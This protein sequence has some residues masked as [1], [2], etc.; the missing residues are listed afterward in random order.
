MAQQSQQNVSPWLDGVR[1]VEVLPIIEADAP[2][3]RVEAGPGTGKTFGLTRLVARLVSPDGEALD[4]TRVLVAA[5]NRVIAKD[6]TDAIGSELER[7]GVET[8]PVVS[9]IHSF[10]VQALGSDDTRLLMPHEELSMLYDVATRHPEVAEP[11]TGITE[12]QR[13]FV[14]HEAGLENHPALWQAVQEWLNDHG[15]KLVGELPKELLSRIRG[16]DLQELL[17]DYVIVDEFQDLTATEQELVSKLVA[18][19]GKLMALGDSNQSIYAFRGNHPDGL[20]NLGELTGTTPELID[21][22]GCQRCPPEIVEIAN[23]LVALSGRQ[24]KPASTEPA[25]LHLLHWDSPAAEF[26][27]LAAAIAENV[28]AHPDDQHLVMVTRRAIAFELKNRLAE[29]NSD[30][31]LRLTFEESLIERWAVREAFLFFCLLTRPDPGTWRAW[32]SYS[33]DSE[34]PNAPK[35]NSDAYLK[36][37]DRCNDRAI[38]AE[39]VLALAGEAENAPRGSGGKMIWQRAA[40]FVQISESRDWA[41]MTPSQLVT[42]LFEPDS[43]FTDGGDADSLER[44]FEL[45]RG[46][47]TEII[48]DLEKQGLT[49]N[50]VLDRAAGELRLMI[51]TREPVDVEASSNLH[52]TTLW[53]AKGLTADHVYV[54]G[55]CEEA[56]PGV[57]RSGSPFTHAAFI[58]ECRRLFYVSVT[59]T[60]KTLVLSQWKRIQRSTALRLGLAAGDGGGN[61]NLTTSQFLGE[62]IELLPESE[63]G[64]SWGGC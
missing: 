21:M 33:V 45:I 56:L 26:D 29:I 63:S 59:R 16:G 13:A 18:P 41:S 51:A 55:L 48:Q 31:R 61:I 53:G 50:Q 43:L 27:G 15:C 54:L 39:D 5:F 6:L 37:K 3:S 44:D 32:F 4:P 25:N 38:R 42:E 14:H 46:Q 7:I 1:G 17:F 58:A 28:A 47:L 60:K 36:F 19:G 2:V 11:F 23:R 40:R 57:Q 8:R 52:A 49:R 9:T 35:R 20:E 64:E 30:L 34:K 12:M 62:V 24:M 22:V 10:C